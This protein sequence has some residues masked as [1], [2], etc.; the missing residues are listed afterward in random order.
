MTRSYKHSLRRQLA[1][2]QPRP[3]MVACALLLGASLGAVQ[4]QN[5]PTTTAAVTAQAAPTAATAGPPQSVNALLARVL[6][7]DPQVR[8][9]QALL[10]ASEQR[11]LQARSRLAPTIGLSANHGDS[12]EVEFGRSLDRRTERVELS[13]RWNLYNNGND[14]AELDGATRDIDAARQDLRRAREE[15]A[16]RVAN[17]YAELQ[18]LDELLPRSAQRLEAVQGLA[19]RVQRQT[20][21]GKTSEADS[22]QA[23]ASQ[24][25]AE[26]VHEQLLADRDSAAQRLGA[27]AG[28]PVTPALPVLLSAPATAS[29]LAAPRPGQLGAAQLR[30]EAAHLRVRPLWS[31]YTPRID[32]EYSQPLSDRTN[33]SLTTE[34]QR[35]WLVTARWDFPVGGESLAR[36]SE[37]QFRAAAASAEAERVLGTVQSEL[38]TLGPRVANAARSVVQLDRQILQYTGLV[39]AGELQFEAGRRS[40]GQLI[41]LHDNRFN[42]E[43]RRADQAGRMLAAQL[44][45]LALSGGL[46][47]ALGQA[48]D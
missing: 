36:R 11:R 38:V 45:Q 8:V 10:Q 33:P 42:A 20:E 29:A 19:K 27:L 41:A 40:L 46:L 5:T 14:K 26:I 47:Q 35:G 6:S 15:V 4:A 24:L 13:L 43:Q 17:A 3:L 21:L 23:Q 32:F 1:R 31:V 2:R 7:R 22:Q 30:A 37:G 39:R 12:K 16:E 18:R 44:R 25:D 34:R 48:A 9:A 28:E